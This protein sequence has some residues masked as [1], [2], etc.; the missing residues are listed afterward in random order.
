MGIDKKYLA[1][2]HEKKSVRKNLVSPNVYLSILVKLYKLLARR[3]GAEFNK[4]V[5]ARMLHTRREQRPV[6]LARLTKLVGEKKEVAVVVGTITNDARLL[7]APK[8]LKVCALHVTE[9]ARKRIVENGGQVLTFDQL[10]QISPDGKGCVLLR[11]NK[12]TE[13]KKHFGLAPGQAGS[14]AKPYKHGSTKR[15]G[16]YGELGRGRRASRQYKKRA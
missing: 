5:L 12:N 13:A 16:R 8:G 9:T 11:G 1:K 2:T 7:D 4:K 10:A 14:H 3:T 6:T 15:E